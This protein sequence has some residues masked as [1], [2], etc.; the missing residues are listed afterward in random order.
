[1]QLHSEVDVRHRVVQF[2]G[3]FQVERLPGALGLLQ[4]FE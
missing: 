2:P 4:R 3:R 1:M